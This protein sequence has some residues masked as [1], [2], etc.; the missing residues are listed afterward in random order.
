[1]S[2][3]HFSPLQGYICDSIYTFIGFLFALPLWFIYL[4]FNLLLMCVVRLGLSL[5][6]M[7]GEELH[8]SK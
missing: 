2:H 8:N 4:F 3:T 5:V 6:S 7:F 1:M